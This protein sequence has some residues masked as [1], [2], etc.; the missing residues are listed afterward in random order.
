MLNPNDANRYK[1]PFA[2]ANDEGFLLCA[3]QTLQ[4]ANYI[5]QEIGYT[6]GGSGSSL[7]LTF[8]VVSWR[9]KTIWEEMIG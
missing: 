3:G 2:G 7:I 1:L 8:E 5:Y 9:V 6:Y 4:V